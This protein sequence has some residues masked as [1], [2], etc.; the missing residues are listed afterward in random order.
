MPWP[1]RTAVVCAVSA[2]ALLLMV[3]TGFLLAEPTRASWFALGIGLLVVPATA[4]LSVLV[5][6]RR[7]G[8]VV[9]LLLGLLS[10]SVAAVVAK[11][12]WLQWLAATDDPG[13]WGW[14]VA[15]TAENAWWILASFALLLLYFPNGQVPSARWRW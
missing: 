6:Q 14:L 13:R 8:A 5:T 3:A 10:L 11:E 7:D 1:R 4:S 12:I 2:A 9:G 15:A